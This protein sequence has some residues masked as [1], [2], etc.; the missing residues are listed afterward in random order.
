[1][2]RV[3]KVSW[4]MVISIG[5]AVLLSAVTVGVL[6]Y[7]FGFPRA[8]AGL[9]FLGL[10]GI[11]GFG[12]MIFKKDP[13]PVQMDE[14]DREIIFKA[15][16]VSMVISYLVFGTLSMGIWAAYFYYFKIEKISI[17]VLPNIYLAAGITAFFFNAL[18]ILILY[19]R[20][21]TREGETK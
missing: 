11:G 7:L 18:M 21:N 13:G 12:E 2:N 15:H 5:T 4:L 1:M 9:G 20:D 19:G 6:Y 3:Q 14:R 17:H 8:W 10:T 16:R